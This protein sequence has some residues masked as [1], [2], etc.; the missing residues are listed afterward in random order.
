MV[1]NSFE[2]IYEGLVT[3]ANDFAGRDDSF[4]LK[5]LLNFANDIGF[6]TYS[7]KWASMKKLTLQTLKVIVFSI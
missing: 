1:L 4:R 3:K 7:P 6:S 2:T 5:M